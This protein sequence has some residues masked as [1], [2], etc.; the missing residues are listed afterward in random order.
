MNW[1]INRS[2]RFV[3][4]CW[5]RCGRPPPALHS[6]HEFRQGLGSRLP[7]TEHQRDAL[8]DRDPPAPR[9]AAAGRG[10]AHHAHRRPHAAGL[11]SASDKPSTAELCEWCRDQWG[12]EI[13]TAAFTSFVFACVAFVRN[14]QTLKCTGPSVIYLYAKVFC[15]KMMCGCQLCRGACWDS[16]ESSRAV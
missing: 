6:A 5:Y 7:T 2:C 8:L 10:S 9:A 12:S 13:Y 11:R 1:S 16:F 14:I 15:M 3:C 4:G